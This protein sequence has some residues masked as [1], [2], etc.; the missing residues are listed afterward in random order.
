MSEET[1]DTEQAGSLHVSEIVSAET[2]EQLEDKLKAFAADLGLDTALIVDPDGA[3]VAGIS[4]HQ[5]FMPDVI[6]ALVA[7][8]EAA[9]RALVAEVDDSG[10]FESIHH[11]DSRFL[12]IRELRKKF[13]LVAISKNNVPAGLVR[14]RALQVN[15]ELVHVLFS[16]DAG[17]QAEAVVVDDLFAE[18]TGAVV[19]TRP[20]SAVAGLANAADTLNPIPTRA[21]GTRPA[22]AVEQ[23][24]ESDEAA[25]TNHEVK[26]QGVV[27]NQSEPV[28]ENDEAER[29]EE[30]SAE[31]Q[32]HDQND[33]NGADPE[34][35]SET[36]AEEPAVDVAEHID[37]DATSHSEES[38]AGEFDDETEA[39][40]PIDEQP[41]DEQSI[42]R[43]LEE[44]V[45]STS[46]GKEIIETINFDE[47]EVV[48]DG[49]EERAEQLRSETDI[50]VSETQSESVSETV[51]SSETAAPV[52]DSIFEIDDEDDDDDDDL[53]DD[54]I[55]EGTEAVVSEPVEDQKEE[56][57]LNF[58]P[59]PEPEKP[60]VKKKV[61][62]SAK[63]AKKRRR[64]TVT[65]TRKVVKASPPAK[66]TVEKGNPQKD[67]AEAVPEKQNAPQG[68]VFF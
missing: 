25:V 6:S 24:V 11:G 27:T 21:P 14:E 30:P 16:E 36:V 7:S 20:S 2:A 8:V 60:Q 35:A 38:A 58:T 4:V 28:V 32:P 5:G 29:A 48:F 34:A 22:G 23:P 42:D 46:S 55:D 59:A 19:K 53:L 67:A 13:L 43:E 45:E 1:K 39:H 52:M 10:E 41:F 49:A 47:P 61:V 62:I 56:P 64:V 18:D 66:E 57:T 3:F 44:R 9:V 51:V 12:Y 26:D 33:A 65:P 37:P 31:L 17:F 68:P 54:D 40:E 50:I 15:Q 63:P